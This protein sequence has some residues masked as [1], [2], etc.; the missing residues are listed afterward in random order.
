LPPAATGEPGNGAAKLKRAPI[1]LLLCAAC[2]GIS[3]G[4]AF[5]GG[6]PSWDDLARWGYPAPVRVWDGALWGLFT[7]I[8]VHLALWHLAF[9]LY[10]LWV[11]GSAVE[12]EIG[13]R[14]YAGFVVVS[15]IVSSS[16]QL[17]VSGATGHGFSGVGYAFFGLIWAARR[18]VPTFARALSDRTHLLFLG[19]L[20]AGILATWMG[21]FVVGN[22]AHVGGLL[23]G[24]LCARPLVRR[25]ISRRLVFAGTALAV[26]LSLVAAL[27]SP[28]SPGW[29]A[30]KAYKAHLAGQYDDAIAGYRRSVELG[31]DRLW[32]LENMAFAYQETGAAKELAAT[33]AEMRSVNP[34]SAAR[35]E[36]ELTGSREKPS[37]K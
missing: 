36:A 11:F 21:A 9:N 29:V 31:G 18:D 1:T 22:A 2:V 3:A 12:R 16:A 14:T 15:A 6:Q 5:Q 17:A 26:V 28:W 27:W 8:F 23:F 33:L 30:H 13:S 32:A 20:I 25:T 24:L 37:A 35:V 19:W 34:E 4:I 7:S 10:W